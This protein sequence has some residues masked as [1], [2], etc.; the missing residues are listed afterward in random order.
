MSIEKESPEEEV[1]KSAAKDEETEEKIVTYT[2]DESE[3]EKIRKNSIQSRRAYQTTQ[4]LRKEDVMEIQK[5]RA[6]DLEDILE[7]NED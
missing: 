3:I 1:K 5:S 7:D 2:L 4:V 6:K